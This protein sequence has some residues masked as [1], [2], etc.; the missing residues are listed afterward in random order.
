[1]S[2]PIVGTAGWSVDRKVDRFARTGSMLERYASVFSGVEVNSS[3]YRRHRPAT[4]QR[5][6]DSVPGGF[7]FAVKLARTVTHE[8]GLVDA[9][10]EIETFF[11]DVA[12]LQGKLGPI[13]VQLPPK[14]EFDPSVAVAFLK[15]LRKHWSGRIEIEPRH[16]SWSDG[17]ALDMLRDHDTGLVYADPQGN[18]LRQVAIESQSSYLRL[19]GSPK[20]YFSSYSAEDLTGFAALLGPHFWCI[21]D[22]TASGAAQINGIEMLDI[23]GG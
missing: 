3:F 9:D 23:L 16:V 11:A 13:L 4:W 17:S 20:V 12:P 21:F 19:H 10:A 14:L 1:M 18:E 15:C 2:K 5:W 8:R 7:M 6:H 22:N